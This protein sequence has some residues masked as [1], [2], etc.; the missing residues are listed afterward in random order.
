HRKESQRENDDARD[1]KGGSDEWEGVRRRLKSHID[2]TF[3][4]RCQ[5]SVSRTAQQR[6]FRIGRG[7]PS[8]RYG[9][10]SVCILTTDAGPPSHVQDSLPRLSRS[11]DRDGDS[12]TS[13]SRAIG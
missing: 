5:H 6:K 2:V 12:V 10:C 13:H 9:T 4:R 7:C 8:V 3:A 11:R 1:K